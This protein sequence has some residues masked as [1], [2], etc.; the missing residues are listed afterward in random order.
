MSII[1]SD[2]KLQDEKLQVSDTINFT[3]FSRQVTLMVGRDY[4]VEN[5][6]WG[7]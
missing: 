7:P 3:R 4:P 1:I 5:N 2:E 6:R